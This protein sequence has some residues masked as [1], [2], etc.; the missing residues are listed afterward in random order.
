MGDLEGRA[1]VVTG[2]GTGIG[3]GIVRR[4][5]AEGCRLLV[6]A[7]NSVAGAEALR[8]ELRDGGAAIE[9]MAADFRDPDAA[10][11]VVRAAIERYGQLDILVNNAGF[12]LD[13]PFLEGATARWQDIFNINLMA[14]IT[15]SQDA[16]RHMVERGAGRI[17]NIS[18]V[19]G[20]V[21]MP[22]NVIYAATKAGINGFTRALALA[23]APHGVTCNVIAPGAIQVDRYADQNLNPSTI[24]A[25][26][27]MRRVGQPREIAAA[28]VYLASDEA[29]YVS[30]EV[31]YVDGAL[32]TAMALQ[33]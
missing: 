17:V 12:T 16:A 7:S 25:A 33:L 15:A 6:S 23:L 1:A 14:M 24:G 18:S 10:R 4:L 27:P 20:F 28:V 5:A 2:G 13:E 26:I 9:T 22:H 29:S 8:D 32:T 21:H 3:A 31:L 11:G 19:H 30:G